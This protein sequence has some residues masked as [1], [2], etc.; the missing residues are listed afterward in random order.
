MTH[1]LV[2]PSAVVALAALTLVAQAGAQQREF[3]EAQ[4][5]NQTALREY[6]WQS[7][8]ELR[9]NGE[10]KNVR[11]EHVRFDI[12]GRLQKTAIGGAAPAADSSRSGPGPAGALKR[13]VVAKKQE[14]FKDMLGALATL[15]ES[16]AHLS[17]DRMK[18]FVAGSV[19]TPGQG[20]DSGS[21]RIQG[22]DLLSVG[23]QMTVWIDPKG[24]ALRRVEISTRYDGGSVSVVAEYRRLD[25]GLSYPARST[26]RY[27]SKGVEV[28]TETFDYTRVP[29]R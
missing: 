7:R 26:L 19:I 16:Y 14:E 22:R 3:A 2:R 29:M 9:V 23:D 5:A 18:A 25:S 6:S 17:P 28:V 4:Q 13:R 15:A 24:F 1:S 11:L 12:D 27:P 20:I 21:V 10:V 8:T